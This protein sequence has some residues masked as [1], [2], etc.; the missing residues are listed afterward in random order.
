MFDVSW[1]ELLVL[2]GLGALLV[3]KRDLPKAAGVAGRQVGRLVGLLQGARARADRFAARSELRQLQNEVRSGLRELDAV[4]SELVTS[5]TTTG[6][7]GRGLGPLTSGVNKRPQQQQQQQTA[8]IPST[9]SID[10]KVGAT[11]NAD[12][13]KALAMESA[14]AAA[15]SSTMRDVAVRPRSSRSTAYQMTAAM[16]E[17]HWEAR[18]TSF[19]SAAERGVG[20][21][22]SSEQ[23][24]GSMLLAKLYQESLL[25]DQYDQIER[26]QDAVLQSK[27]HKIMQQKQ[28]EKAEEATAKKQKDAPEKPKES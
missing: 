3:G 14:A 12:S 7:V 11:L 28:Q 23:P 25:L 4:R 6:L 2:G 5:M 16:A 13:R 15:A 8:G 18:G 1:G 9:A 10:D 24:T 26:D 20:M 19:R 21:G 27:V 17:Q 22:V